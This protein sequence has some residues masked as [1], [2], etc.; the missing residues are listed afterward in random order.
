LFFYSPFQIWAFIHIG[1]V[2]VTVQRYSAHAGKLKGL[3]RGIIHRTSDFE[4]RPLWLRS[5]KR[6]KVSQHLCIVLL[7]YSS[8]ETDR[9][10]QEFATMYWT[11]LHSYQICF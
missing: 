3:P 6:S 4:L 7:H 2:D 5:D 10:W 8:I 9:R 1:T 11:S